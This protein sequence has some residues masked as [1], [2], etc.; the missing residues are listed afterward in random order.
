[1]SLTHRPGGQD[2]VRRDFVNAYARYWGCPPE[3]A[4]GMMQHVESTAVEEE[5]EAARAIRNRAE[6][7]GLFSAAYFEGYDDALER[8][9]PAASTPH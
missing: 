2:T 1:M 9:L 5:V 6:G 8:V 3:Y 4:E 7:E